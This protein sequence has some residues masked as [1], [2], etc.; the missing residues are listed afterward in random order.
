M[1]KKEATITTLN[2]RCKDC[3]RCVRVCSVNAIGIENNQ[4]YIDNDKCVLCGTCVREC[5]QSAKVY[6]KDGEKVLELIKNNKTAVSLAPSFSA[7]YGG[8]LSKRLPSALRKLGFNYVCETSEGAQKVTEKALNLGENLGGISS[9]CP[10]VV[11]Y[12]QKYKPQHLTNLMPLVSPMIAHGKILKDRL[13]NDVKVVFIGP[14]IAKKAEAELESTV[15]AIDAVITFSELDELLEENGIVIK[16]CPISNFDND[17]YIG[18]AKLFALPGGMLK[19]AQRN[20]DIGSKVIHT[21]GS[22]NIKEIFAN[23]V[24]ELSPETIEPL[25]CKQGCINGPGVISE[26]NIFKRRADLIRYASSHKEVAKKSSLEEINLETK[27]T[28]ELIEEKTVSDDQIQDIFRETGKSRKEMRLDCGACGYDSCLEQ[29]KAVVRGLAQ[30]S[31]CMPYM[32]RLAE[33]RT[34]QIIKNSPNGIVIVDGNLEILS[35]NPAFMEFFTCNEFIIGKHISYLIESDSYEKLIVGKENKLESVINLYGKRFH[36]ILYKLP[37]DSNCVGVYSD[38]TS[39]QLTKKKLVNV[40]EQTIQQAQEL[41]DHQVEMSL[42]IAKFL[43]EST[44][45]GEEIVER[46]LKVYE[47]E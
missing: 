44:A 33:S 6:R 7:I 26:K 25:F 9:A 14:C 8:G 1:T 32:R 39:I 2:A 12:I 3:Y 10:V 30:K 45:K 41:L 47:Q 31:M 13:G 37:K 22:E 4:A 42:Q 15:G 17:Q 36:Q 11:S 46:L 24:K 38:I 28:D 19:T 35:I 40:R 16:D 23:S 20:V 18:H 34:D 5:P 29:A 21:S 43:G 27:F